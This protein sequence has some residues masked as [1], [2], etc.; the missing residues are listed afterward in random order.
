MEKTRYQ[1]GVDII[2]EYTLTDNK[3][4]GTHM[5]IVDEFKELAPDLESYIVE[6]AFGD[7]YS[8]DGLTNHQRTIAT[9][10]SLVTLGTEPQLELHINT[11]LTIGLTPNEIVGTVMHLIPYT[12]FPR[13]L[14][15]LKVVKKVFAQRNVKIKDLEMQPN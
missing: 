2:K 4:I 5:N 7:I 11:G 1:Q 3:E 10:S 15:A 6:F 9:I 8:R 14:N 12:G 13:V